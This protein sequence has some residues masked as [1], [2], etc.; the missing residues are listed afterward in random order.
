MGF[1]SM[2]LCDHHRVSSSSVVR[3]SG[4]IMEDCGFKCH[5]EL[6]FFSELMPFLHLTTK[7]AEKKKAK[8]AMAGEKREQVLSSIQVLCL[9]SKQ[10]LA[11]AISHQKYHAQPM[12]EKK[13]S[14]SKKLSKPPPSKI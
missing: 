4:Q 5:L 12:C 14:C 1:E 9:T 13:I 3:A 10:I 11:Q 2:T 8:G 6:G 7:T